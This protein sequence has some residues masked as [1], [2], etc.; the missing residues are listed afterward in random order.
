MDQDA[1]VS[2]DDADGLDRLASPAGVE[3][4]EGDAAGGVD[5]DPV[6]LA[7]DA[8]RGLVDVDGRHG[9]QALDGGVLPLCEGLVQLRDIGEQRRL[10]DCPAGQDLERLRDPLERDHLRDEEVDRPG[11]DAGTV[12]QRPGHVPGEA[13]PGLGA[14]AR[15]ALDLGVDMVLDGLED[16]IDQGAPFVARA[17]GAGEVGAAAPALL[18]DALLAA[19]HDA[20]VGRGRRVL[21]RAPAAGAGGAARGL[22]LRRAGRRQARV[23]AGLRGGLLHE[24]RDQQLQQRHQCVDR[25]DALRCHRAVALEPFEGALL[26]VEAAAQRFPVHA[27]HRLTR[28]RPP[29]SRRAPRGARRAAS[30]GSAGPS[31]RRGA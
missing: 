7:V 11:A 2:R 4:L 31:S 27:G 18:D 21:L 10:G 5:M 13:S 8:Q 17:G 16:D 3:D 25:G 29:S 24:H 15:A 1:L 22:V 23:A 12:L 28:P 6:V 9:E 26:L 30:P 14:A 20:R 19:G